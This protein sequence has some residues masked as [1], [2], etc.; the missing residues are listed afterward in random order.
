VV[1]AVVAFAE[2]ALCA[3]IEIALVAGPSVDFFLRD[4]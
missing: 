2:E 4:L 1:G 3:L